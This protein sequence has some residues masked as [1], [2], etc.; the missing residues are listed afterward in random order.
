MT[1]AWAWLNLDTAP[2]E[3]P[4]LAGLATDQRVVPF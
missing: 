4:N 1:R 3:K 2:A